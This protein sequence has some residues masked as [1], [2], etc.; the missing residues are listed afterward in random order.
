MKDITP[1]KEIIPLKEKVVSE[2]EGLGA[3][4]GGLGGRLEA[5]LVDAINKDGNLVNDVINE[6]IDTE[7]KGILKG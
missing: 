1:Q 2:N 4:V 5:T 7:T 3:K 6:R